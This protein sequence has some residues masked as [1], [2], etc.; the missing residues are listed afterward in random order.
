MCASCLR[1]TAQQVDPL[2]LFGV[3][4]AFPKQGLLFA[5]AAKPK[6]RHTLAAAAFVC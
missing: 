3:V 1:L 2:L 5:V 6:E 4:H